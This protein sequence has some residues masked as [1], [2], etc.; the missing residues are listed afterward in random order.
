MCIVS[1]KAEPPFA[2]DWMSLDPLSVH[3]AFFTAS[4]SACFRA[5]QGLSLPLCRTG[6]HD[7]TISFKRLPKISEEK[8]LSDRA[9]ALT[10]K[11][12][13]SKIRD[14]LQLISETCWILLASHIQFHLIQPSFTPNHLQTSPTSPTP[15]VLPEF[16]LL[17]PPPWWPV[18]GN[19]VSP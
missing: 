1:T 17:H 5:F 4:S 11:S 14:F 12:Y 13:T 18:P 6:K 7:S 10:S 19:E 15:F 3:A 2:I 9:T 8:K 16:L